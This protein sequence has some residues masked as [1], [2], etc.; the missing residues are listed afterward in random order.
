MS[1]LTDTYIYSMQTICN[2]CGKTGH[3]FQQCKMPI[4][5]YGIIL[6]SFKKIKINEKNNQLLTEETEEKKREVQ[7]LMIR[8]KDSF[9]FIDIIRGKYSPSYLSQIQHLVDEL[10]EDEKERMKIQPF[11]QLWKNMWGNEIN[12]S[13][14]NKSTKLT[15]STKSDK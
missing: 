5:S 1:V 2:N 4:N 8:R 6:F 12:T 9:G 3:M 14:I 7:F 13:K 15:K 10:T 11:S